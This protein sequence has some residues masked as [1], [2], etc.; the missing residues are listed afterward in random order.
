MNFAKRHALHT[1]VIS[2]EM[3]IVDA[4]V[5]A[6]KMAELRKKLADYDATFIFNGFVLQ[7]ATKA[8]L[9]F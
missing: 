9:Y 4:S 6:A 3:G 1:V 2:N 5:G 8:Y 7:A